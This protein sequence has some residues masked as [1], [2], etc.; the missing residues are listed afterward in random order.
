[1]EM[2]YRIQAGAIEITPK[3]ENRLTAV[4]VTDEP[5]LKS[6]TVTIELDDSDNHFAIPPRKQELKVWLGYKDSGL[7]FVGVYSVT[8]V[9]WKSKPTTLTITATAARLTESIRAPR[10]RAWS[11]VTFAT[12]MAKIAAEHGYEARVAPSLE[13][14]RF[15]HLSQTQESDQNLLTRLAR[16]H[17][18][19]FKPAGGYL[20]LM[21]RGEEKTVKGK[22]LPPITIRPTDISGSLEFDTH[23]QGKY[24]SVKARVRDVQGNKTDYVTVGVGEPVLELKQPYP[25]KER[26][27][28]AALAALDQ[29]NRGRATF[30]CKLLRANPTLGA[31]RPVILQGF[32]SGVD[33]RYI[34][35]SATTNWHKQGGFV[36]NISG[37]AAK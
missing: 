22:L 36:T 37:E 12:M 1:M 9:G 17:N 24:G 30:K 26:A 16:D 34:V 21:P 35:Q 10:T 23:D 29:K 5:G 6:D 33:G 14:V 13:N 7:E 19:V 4:T 25:N 11:D 32:K 2:I 18:A 3:L 27:E 31:E 8:K 20:L 28:A 15:T